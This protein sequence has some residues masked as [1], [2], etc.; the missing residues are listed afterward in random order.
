[1]LLA[2]LRKSRRQQS[3]RTLRPSRRHL[4]SRPELRG[5][6]RKRDQSAVLSQLTSTLYTMRLVQ[7][8]AVAPRR[9]IATRRGRYRR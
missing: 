4:R 9:A 8:V 2:A 6:P 5:E 7:K 3:K 1:L